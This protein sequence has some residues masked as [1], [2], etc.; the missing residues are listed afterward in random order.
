MRLEQPPR[1]SHQ[2]IR[3]CGIGEETMTYLFGKRSTEPESD[4]EKGG[5]V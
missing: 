1:K 2:S 4:I 3:R 5:G